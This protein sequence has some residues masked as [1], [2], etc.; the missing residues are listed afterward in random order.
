MS[1][2]TSPIP[3]MRPQLPDAD[4]LLPYLREI[5]G[6]RVY[7]NFG[8]LLERFEQRL[9]EALALEEG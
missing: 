9:S 7:T 8:P 2:V 6:A 4:T 5:D 1:D 3:L